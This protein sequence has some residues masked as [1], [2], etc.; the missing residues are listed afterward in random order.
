MKRRDALVAFGAL[1]MLPPLSSCSRA[2]ETEGKRAMI[3]VE[4][5]VDSDPESALE[6]EAKPLGRA[7]LVADPSDQSYSAIEAPLVVELPS[8]LV[9]AVTCERIATGHFHI[10]VSHNS[11]LF[12]MGKYAGPFTVR[13]FPASHSSYI[14]H[15][16]GNPG[17]GPN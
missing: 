16:A 12:S 13:I 7:A 17:L 4:I 11:D 2:A 3:N 15:L 10:G 8:G 14:L 6:N 9:V 1:T 5:W